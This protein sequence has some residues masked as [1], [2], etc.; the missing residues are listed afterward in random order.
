MVD[1]RNIAN[2][3]SF[4]DMDSDVFIGRELGV[5]KPSN[6]VDLGVDWLS[7]G[8]ITED[9]VEEGLDVS[10]Q[11]FT[12]W[13]G[14]KTGKTKT[15]GT[16]K[17]QQVSAAETNPLVTELFYGHTP[18]DITVDATTGIAQIALPDAVPTVARPVAFKFTDGDIIW[19]RYNTR[20]EITDRGSVSYNNGDLASRQMT[21]DMV[22]TDFWLT[23]D[24]AFG[25]TLAPATP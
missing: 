3:R 16:E 5:P 18:A 8:W 21:F 20:A 1:T 19:I 6:L 9:G 24:P 14:G 4:G 11:K 13:Q 22:G 12:L 15:T 23:N 2:L 7:L 17:T 10:S 25:G